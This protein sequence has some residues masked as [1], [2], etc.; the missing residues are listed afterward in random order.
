MDGSR[1]GPKTLLQGVSIQELDIL[2]RQADADLHTRILPSVASE[3][4]QVRR[5]SLILVACRL[6]QRRPAFGACNSSGMNA[7]GFRSRGKS[8]VVGFG[9]V[10]AVAGCSPAPV[11][12]ASPTVAATPTIVA[13]PTGATGA[14]LRV[15]L[16]GKIRCASFPYGCGP[17]L[18]V[19]PAGTTVS[20]AWR[21][22]LTDPFWAPDYSSGG[23]A[24]HFGATV[25]GTVPKLPLGM[26]E[27]VISLLGSYDVVS[28]NPDGSKALDLLGRCTLDV[29]VTSVDQVVSVLV[30]FMPGQDFDASC[31]I[32]QT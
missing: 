6:A 25:V 19:L 18:T 16:G 4:D 27:L 12:S 13:T 26:H 29:E 17:T 9:V 23:T 11:P 22:P 3:S 21:P 10:L 31:T 14:T 7:G 1:P 28:F 32:V 24:D 30:T 5:A 8:W 20:D 15:K 2:V